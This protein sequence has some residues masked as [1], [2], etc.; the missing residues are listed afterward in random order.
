VISRK[1]RYFLFLGVPPLFLAG[2]F[3]A[4]VFFAVVFLAVVFL[5][6]VFLA[7]SFL[8][9]NLTVLNELVTVFVDLGGR[10]TMIKWTPYE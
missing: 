9:A 1:Q 7:V 4:M 3:F 8:K 10:S 2:V 6:A 5:A